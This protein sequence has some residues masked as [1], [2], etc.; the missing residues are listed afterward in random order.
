ME[1]VLQIV[2]IQGDA[3]QRENTVLFQPRSHPFC[4]CDIPLPDCNT[5]FVYML[6]STKDKSYAYI[7]KTVSIRRRLEQHNSGYGAASTSPSNLHPFGVFALIC[8][9]EGNKDLRCCVE[10]Q[11]KLKRDSLR[12]NGIL[13][14][15][16]WALAGD[17]VISEIDCQNFNIEHTQLRL[18][19]FFKDEVD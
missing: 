4:V 2:S 1:S 8:G 11:W 19:V 12:R 5:G 7:G 3:N 15:K 17:E 6:V 10:R 16:Q 9:F 18:I 14:L 13:C